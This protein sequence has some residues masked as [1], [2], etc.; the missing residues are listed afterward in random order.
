M[1]NILIT[2]ASRGLGAALSLGVPE[3]E[4][5]V[6]LVSRSQPPQVVDG[7]TRHWIQADLATRDG[8]TPIQQAL[9][10]QRLDTL[11]YNAGIWETHAF[12]D[13]YDFEAVPVEENERI[14]QVNLLSAL[15]CV[16][17]L[18]PN[19]RQSDNAKIILI[20]STS[21][22]DHSDDRGVAY[23][24]S[25]FGLRG[26]AHALRENLREDRIGVT[27][28]NPG[29][30]ATEIPYEHGIEA[31]L[32]SSRGN[33][34]PMQDIVAVVRCVMSLSWAAC[35]KEINLPAMGDEVA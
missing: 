17:K 21:G 34:L 22:L 1:R 7:I 3:S 26:V 11:I 10:D 6:W 29:T 13:H 27:C 24:A 31:V 5:T 4:D 9:G 25:K 16:Q 35:I 8:I 30:I 20:G 33:A 18:L 23:A 32:N 2:G 14:L 12:T 15:T 19:L 28:L